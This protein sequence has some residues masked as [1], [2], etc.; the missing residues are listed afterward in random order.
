MF[1]IKS[2]NIHLNKAS[3]SWLTVV[4]AIEH[5]ALRAPAIIFFTAKTTC[6]NTFLYFGVLIGNLG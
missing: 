2:F 6:K 3:V 4:C 1:V 5:Y